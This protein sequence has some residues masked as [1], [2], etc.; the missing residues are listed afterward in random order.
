MLAKINKAILKNEELIRITNSLAPIVVEI[1]LVFSLK[2]R[3][4]QR[5][6]GIAP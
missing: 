1:L 3:R 4:L 6:A 2:T 5:I